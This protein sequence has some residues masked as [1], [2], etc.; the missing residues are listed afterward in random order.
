M[1]TN[2][3]KTADY[4]AVL[5]QKYGEVGTS[6]RKKFEEE[7]YSFYT[8]QMLAEARREAKMTQA[9]LAQKVNSTKSYISQL[10]HGRAVPSASLFFQIM[11]ALGIEVLFRKQTSNFV[12]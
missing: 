9:E 8:A 2:N 10:E 7:A 6:E 4:S 5:A 1:Q 3:H 11:S 12:V